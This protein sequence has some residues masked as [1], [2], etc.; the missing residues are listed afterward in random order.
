MLTLLKMTLIEG[1]QKLSTAYNM[2]DYCQINVSA[3]R[4][5]QLE[6]KLCGPF[7]MASEPGAQKQYSKVF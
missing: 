5:K 7:K 4:Q 3:Q 2:P 6:P 1:K